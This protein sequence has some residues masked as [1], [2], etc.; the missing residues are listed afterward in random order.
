MST[1]MVISSLLLPESQVTHNRTN[2]L[3]SADIFSTYKNRSETWIKKKDPKFHSF[4]FSTSD[5]KITWREK[6]YLHHYSLTESPNCY[7]GKRLK[8]IDITK[9]YRQYCSNHCKA[10]DQKLVELTRKR[11][12]DKWGV[13][14][15]MKLLSIKEKQKS[16]LN[17]RYGVDNASQIDEVKQKILRA[18]RKNWGVDY[19][20]QLPDKRQALSEN[21]KLHSTHL[22]SINK[23][24]LEI[25]LHKKF[26]L[27]GLEFVSIIDTSIYLARC[28]KRHEF[29]IH[30]NTLNDR[31][32]N[33]N[34]ICT[35][36]NPIKS[37]SDGEKQLSQFIE[38]IYPGTI[39]KNYRDSYEIDVFLPDL[40]VG[41]EFNGIYWHS[42]VYRDKFY[43]DNK[44]KYFADKGV[45]IFYVWE[46]DWINNNDM[47]KLYIKYIID[48]KNSSNLDY[49]RLLVENIKSENTTYISDNMLLGFILK[50]F[51]FKVI[52]NTG[53][54]VQFISNAK[55]L[56]LQLNETFSP[57]RVSKKTNFIWLNSIE[58][59]SLQTDC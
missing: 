13:D 17:E 27:L 8:F 19:I 3:S 5:L 35:K 25:K 26:N 34:T 54:T 44:L 57:V 30:K 40:N 43:H 37:G 28:L 15:P 22:N 33:K 4:I 53:P 56:K 58:I 2:M 41:F 16:T 59:L 55:R 46:D 31:T 45:N 23:S 20:S 36:C 29:H 47:I 10:N 39:L 12:L 14:N 48:I 21:M 52:R 18:N 11:N 24:N 38:S 1:S 51:G 7:C 32:R 9:G 50:N 49:V 42:S 6:L